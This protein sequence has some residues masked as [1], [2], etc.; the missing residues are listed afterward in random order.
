VA[1]IATIALVNAVRTSGAA[2]QTPSGTSSERS[3]NVGDGLSRLE[4][5]EKMVKG[6]EAIQIKV[7]RPRR[8]TAEL[9]PDRPRP[10]TVEPEPQAP[11][12]AEP[13]AAEPAIAVSQ[14]VAPTSMLSD[15]PSTSSLDL[16]S[17]LSTNWGLSSAPASSGFEEALAMLQGRK[18]GDP[19]AK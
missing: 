14:T 5:V 8:V 2:G 19:P 11:V 6:P 15:M 9:Q 4:M 7:D 3:G 16:S 1:L 12:A 17:S 13:V 18:P 10:V